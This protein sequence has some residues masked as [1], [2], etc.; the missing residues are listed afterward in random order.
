MITPMLA[1][2]LPHGLDWIGI[3]FIM[4]VIYL[5]PAVILFFIIYFA[6]KLAIKHANR[7]KDQ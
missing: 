5:L 2:G 7:D 1:F 4:P 6:V 3:I